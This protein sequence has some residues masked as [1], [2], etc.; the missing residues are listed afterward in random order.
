MKVRV[1]SIVGAILVLSTTGVAAAPVV[2]LAGPAPGPIEP[3]QN[4]RPSFEGQPELRLLVVGRGFDGPTRRYHVTLRALTREATFP[5]AWRF[6]PFGCRSG[7]ASVRTFDSDRRVPPLSGAHS[8]TSLVATFVESEPASHHVNFA[9][10]A[11]SD[12]I[13]AHPESTYVLGEFRFDLAGARA[14]TSTPDS[15]GCASQVLGLQ[16]TSAWIEDGSGQPIVLSFGVDCAGWNDD[17]T[18]DVCFIPDCSPGPC[19]PQASTCV[20]SLP[21]P[22][23]SVSWGTIK[24]RY[25]ARPR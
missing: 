24:D 18:S 13:V 12:G 25:R 21:T 11:L 7:G 9:F 6:D 23:R 1:L 15:C 8:F 4:L 22:A 3:A 17:G 19:G 14:G 20:D 10:D 16:I 5:D 2:W